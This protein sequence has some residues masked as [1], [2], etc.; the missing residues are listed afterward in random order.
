[1][2]D[3]LTRLL[4]ETLHSHEN[5]AQP[6][7]GL[8]ARVLQKGRS[9]RNRRRALG[10]GATGLVAAVAVTALVLGP[11]SRQLPNPGPANGRTQTPTPTSTPSSTVSADEDPLLAYAQKLPVGLPVGWLPRAETRGTGP[12]S[13]VVVVT[14]HREV[15][16]PAEANFAFDLTESAEGLLVPAHGRGFTGGGPDPDQAL[17]LIRADGSLTTLHK[18]AFDGLAVDPSG[19][20]YALSEPGMGAYDPVRITVAS[21]SP[22][23]SKCC[24]LGTTHS[25][26]D[27]IGTTVTGWTSRG[28]LLSDASRIW[29]W[30]PGTSSRTELSGVSSASVM[31]TDPGQLLVVAGKVGPGSCLHLYTISSKQMGPVLTCGAQDGWTVSPDGR[32]AVVGSTVVDLA[33]GSVGPDL[34]DKLTSRFTHWDDST[35]VLTDVRGQD[36]R[37]AVIDIWV[38]CDVTTGVCE[39]APTSAL[40]DG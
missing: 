27:P 8:S 35:H 3:E 36:T 39:Q 29:L 17:Y 34:L 2:S 10:W 24:D 19:K 13:R 12:T 6:I 23:T 11:V 25:R 33:N 16:L 15:T 37:G 5:D 30:Q 14:A 40:I 20:Q 26:T 22:R 21:L 7:P 18:G 1:M 4:T 28:L 32:R 38:R 9:A 31:P